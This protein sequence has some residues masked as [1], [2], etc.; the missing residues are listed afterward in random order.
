[1]FV[2]L[3]KIVHYL[4][5]NIVSV[6]INVNIF[7]VIYLVKKQK[8]KVFKPQNKKFYYIEK[9]RMILFVARL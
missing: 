7:P 5:H 8:I 4:V 1:M 9:R 3:V 2:G 6:K